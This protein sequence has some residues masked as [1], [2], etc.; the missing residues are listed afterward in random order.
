MSG[1]NE[2]LLLV[3]YRNEMLSPLPLWPAGNLVSA[4]K[5]PLSTLTSPRHDLVVRPVMLRVR[6]R[7]VIMP[8]AYQV[9]LNGAN[10]AHTAH[11]YQAVGIRRTVETA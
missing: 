9:Q 1:N 7:L 3:I 6:A 10:R 11:T 4:R 8:D 5:L 2:N